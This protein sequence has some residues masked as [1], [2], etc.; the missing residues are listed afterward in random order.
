MSLWHAASLKVYSI[1]G[2]H[3]CSLVKIKSNYNVSGKETAFRSW[4]PLRNVS[5]PWYNTCTSS[6]LWIFIFILT[7]PI[8]IYL[9]ATIHSDI[10]I[11]LCYIHILKILS[12]GMAQLCT[13]D[14]CI[15]ASTPSIASC[16]QP[17][18]INSWHAFNA[19]G[20]AVLNGTNSRASIFKP[21]LEV[22]GIVGLGMRASP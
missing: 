3:A 18:L 4:Y 11:P 17:H 14:I 7:F 20:N 22:D 9:E 21:E 12:F 1:Q 13:I 5:I 16:Q 19:S 10:N 2:I 15:S 8:V 6:C